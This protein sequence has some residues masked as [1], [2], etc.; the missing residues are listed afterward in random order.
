MLVSGIV[1]SLMY[2]GRKPSGSIADQLYVSW[3]SAVLLKPVS[4]PRPR[5]DLPTPT[6]SSVNRV[7]SLPRM[8]GLLASARASDRNRLPCVNS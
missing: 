7:P 2:M 1:H 6:P 4:T 5:A 8:T 3:G